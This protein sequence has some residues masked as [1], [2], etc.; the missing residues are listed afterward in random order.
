MNIYKM[1]IGVILLLCNTYFECSKCTQSH[2]FYMYNL[3]VSTCTI[4]WFLHVQ[5]HGFDMYNPMVST[6]TILW[7]M[8]L[9]FSVVIIYLVLGTVSIISICIL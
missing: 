7:E 5:S 2:G 4:P 1:C 8:H 3:M 6:C 9:S